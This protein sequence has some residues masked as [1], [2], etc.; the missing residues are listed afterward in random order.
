[1]KTKLAVS[2]FALSVIVPARAIDASYVSATHIHAAST[3]RHTAGR[4]FQHN[5]G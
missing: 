5:A 2:L 4:R 1:M 3:H